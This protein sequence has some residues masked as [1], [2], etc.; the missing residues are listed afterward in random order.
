MARALA[1]DEHQI[2]ITGRSG[3]RAAEVAAT[4]PDAVRGVGMDV[5]DPDS[6]RA[7]RDLAVSA[8]GGLDVLINNAGLG[9]RTVNPHFLSELQPFW[10]VPLPAFRD[11]VDTNLTGYFLVAA[12]VVPD[13]LASG[14]GRI[15]NVTVNDSTMRRGGFVPYGPSRAGSESLSRIMAAD[16]AHTGVRVNLLLPGGATR[17]GMVPDEAADLPGLLSPDVMAAPVRWL[18]SPQ[19]RDVHDERIVATEFEGWLA[20][21]PG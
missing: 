1:A 16:L 5:R 12:T 14:Q 19:A 7:G 2:V 20:R 3:Q 9:M 18:C 8:L 11:V 10:E 21:R 15:V 4:L 13:L 6:V 17:T